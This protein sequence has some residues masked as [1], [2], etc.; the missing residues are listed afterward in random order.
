MEIA[1][2]KHKEK[3]IMCACHNIWMSKQSMSCERQISFR[4]YKFLMLLN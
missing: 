4:G 3:G 2:R 1:I